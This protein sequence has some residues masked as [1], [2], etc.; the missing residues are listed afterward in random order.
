MSDRFVDLMEALKEEMDV[1]AKS[2]RKP[3]FIY[4]KTDAGDFK[5]KPYKSLNEYINKHESFEWLR[6]TNVF[7]T[8]SAYELK[9]PDDNPEDLN[10]PLNYSSIKQNQRLLKPFVDKLTLTANKSVR[11]SDTPWMLKEQMAYINRSTALSLTIQLISE[12]NI[13]GRFLI[14]PKED[15]R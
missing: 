3:S 15:E 10:E 4:L 11:F 1:I 7:S 6:K 2:D 13:L 5:C 8:I 12:N 14:A 9:R